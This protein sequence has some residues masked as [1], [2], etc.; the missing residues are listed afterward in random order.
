MDDCALKPLMGVK[1]SIPDT[2]S[3][4]KKYMKNATPR[5]NGGSYF[6]Q[7]MLAYNVTFEEITED[8]KWCWQEFGCAKFKR[9]RQPALDS[10]PIL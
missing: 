8:I 9:R 6:I 7:A 10:C 5:M 1:D 3:K 2:V 4:L